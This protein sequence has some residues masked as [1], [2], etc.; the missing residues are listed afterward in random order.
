M[1]PTVL[2]VDD[3]HLMRRWVRHHLEAAG[4]TV[5]DADSGGAAVAA[6]AAALPAVILMDYQMPDLD[7]LSATRILKADPALADV[8]VLLLTASQDAHHIEAAF[9]AGAEDYLTKPINPR[10]LVARLRSMLQVHAD[11]QLIRES[12]RA[13]RE[14]DQFVSELEAAQRVQSAQLPVLPRTLGGW[15]VSGA[16][17]PCAMIGGD[18]Y[19]VVDGDPATIF[20]IDVSGHG[21]GAALVAS[22]VASAFKGL[23]ATRGLVEAAAALNHQLLSGRSNHYACV[24][25][26]RLEGR[27][28][29][30]LNAG[31]P[32]ITLVRR[33]ERLTQ[34]A[35]SGPPPGLVEAGYDEVAIDVEP[36][37]Q[38]VLVSD[39]LTEPFGD[40]DDVSTVMAGLSPSGR[41]DAADLDSR[42]AA[43][44][45]RS[46][47]LTD[48]ATVLV[49]ER[50]PERRR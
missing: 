7:G 48:D 20:L 1:N 6:A 3:D 45:S 24:A 25:A 21:A 42:L 26:V 32:P 10:I 4:F 35:G 2:V 46:G 33:G 29:T 34:V 41:F 27:R 47:T 43:L 38:L 37:D 36:G 8:P 14:R 16:M 19:D 13:I 28:A 23:I 12:E 39:G 40:C 30:V 18:L 5:R 9:D 50:L 17:I 11:R 49:A 31:L 15:S 44:M 22:S